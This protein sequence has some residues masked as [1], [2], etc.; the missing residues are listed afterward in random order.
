M[1]TAH[2]T[3]FSISGEFFTK[4]VRDF[5]LDDEPG[6]AERTVAC[7]M[8][9]GTERIAK[10]ILRGE[11]KLVGESPNIT[12]KPEAPRVRKAFADRVAWVYAGRIKVAGLW[13]R[14][15]ARVTDVGPH[16]MRNSH[17]KKVLVY[18]RG[19]TNRSWH[20]CGK[21]E[22]ILTPLSDVIFEPCSERPHWLPVLRDEATAIADFI[23]AKRPLEERSHSKWYP[24]HE[25]PRVSGRV[26][27][28]RIP[29]E[30]QREI[31]R[32]EDERF[33]LM[34][35]ERALEI[36]QLR[37]KILDQA[38]DD[39]IPL[40]W[41]EGTTERIVL[42]PRAPFLHWAVGRS[43]KART[44]CPPWTPCSPTGLK[45]Q[46][47]DPWH[48]DWMIAAELDLG[49]SY[50]SHPAQGAASALGWKMARELT[51]ADCIVLAEGP[52]VH[53]RVF[54][55]KRKQRGAIGCIAVLPNLHPDYL[56]TVADVAA[57]I[58]EEGGAMA[59]LVQINRERSLPIVRMVGALKRFPEGALVTVDT[60]SAEIRLANLLGDDDAEDEA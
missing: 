34:K 44:L 46:L 12:A 47:D 29:E 23:A 24:H 26:W 49:S 43:R 3:H 41:L 53:A 27:S 25:S 32:L 28:K 58:T 5:L 39:L 16:D 8:G 7:L 22:I 36:E 18:D 55:G 2:T 14:P 37:M 59:H 19:L 10:K 40:S 20:Y 52:L 30:V 13:Y 1:T 42:I 9:E 57:I 48:T 4:A 33:E 6:R 56:E 11:V 60:A 21:R 50:H 51:Q 54:H 15:V 45:M 38:G 17:D 35:A 31:D